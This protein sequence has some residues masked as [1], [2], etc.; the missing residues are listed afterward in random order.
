V[1]S[2]IT[3]GRRENLKA[4]NDDMSTLRFLR[5]GSSLIGLIIGLGIVQLLQNHRREGSGRGTLSRVPSSSD[6][7]LVSIVRDTDYGTLHDTPDLDRISPGEE[8][9]G[10]SNDRDV[11]P[12]DDDST[13]S[14]RE[15][16]CTCQGISDLYKVSHRLKSFARSPEA[17]RLW[18]R[19]HKC[20]TNPESITRRPK[21]VQSG[22]SSLASR[23]KVCFII[24]TRPGDGRMEVIKKTWGKNF[25]KK[26]YF[27]VSLE[28]DNVSYIDAEQNMVH[29]A[30]RNFTDSTGYVVP[31][32]EP[33]R[34]KGWQAPLVAKI[35]KTWEYI[36]DTFPTFW[37]DKCAW[38]VKSDDDTWL[39]AQ[40]LQQ[41]LQCIDPDVERNFGYSCG[42]GVGVYT[43][44]SRKVVQHFKYFIQELRKESEP[45]WFVGDIEDRR[46][47][48]VL[49]RFDVN[50]QRAVRVNGTKR[51]DYVL[52]APDV[53]NE[54][55]VEWARSHTPQEIGCLTM[56]HHSRP[57]V[58]E[59]LTEMLD[60]HLKQTNDGTVC[61]MGW[62]RCE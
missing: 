22:T 32:Y 52:W 15:W 36:S 47:G 8:N 11:V 45:Q 7:T 48:Q 27:V 31:E 10:P 46:I 4:D 59:T 17:S 53:S 33:D 14:C 19:Q 20:T 51:P 62:R 2:K 30:Y 9:A 12:S 58:M 43:G 25:L 41:R 16:N 1:N 3:L 50:I 55:K 38:F 5:L 21:Q 35:M 42:F 28:S 29:I 57:I 13:S 18:W 54:R 40:L 39:N 34:L 26:I 60:D 61:P 37:A 49:M 24:P 56:A 6:L 23:D 44:Y